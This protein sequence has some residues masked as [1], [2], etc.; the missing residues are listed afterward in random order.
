[1]DPDEARYA[2][3]SREMIEQKSYIVPLFNYEPRL[4]KPI[5]FYWSQI[6]SFKLFGINEF[7]ARFPSA[8]AALATIILV[9][10]IAKLLFNIDV[11][12]L[13]IFIFF[14]NILFFAFAK[15]GLLEVL[16]LFSFTL[17]IYFF[18]MAETSLVKWK[19]KRKTLYVLLFFVSLGLSF[20]IKGPVGVLV[21]L[22]IVTVYLILMK[23]F[24]PFSTN[25]IISGI[26]LFLAVIVPW[27]VA[28]ISKEG[29]SKIMILL[30][31]ET[32]ER[33]F[34]GFDHPEPF[35]YYIPIFLAGFFPWSSF[36]PVAVWR[37]G[38]ASLKSWSKEKLFLL[39]WLIFPLLFFSFSGSKLP[40]YILPVLPAASLIVASEWIEE[41][42][43]FSQ[44]NV[45]KRRWLLKSGYTLLTIFIV[46][47]CIYGFSI[48]HRYPDF[49]TFYF[50]AALLSL[51]F[52]VVAFIFLVKKMTVSLFSSILLF[53]IFFL[54]LSILFFMPIVQDMR[55]TK[56]LVLAKL[57]DYPDSTICTYNQKIPSLVFYRRQKVI[58]I[59]GEEKLNG[60][61]KSGMKIIIVASE[62]N[63]ENLSSAL[64]GELKIEGRLRKF[65]ILRPYEMNPP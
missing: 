21:P 20:L 64:K 37:L 44:G 56:R 38:K 57:V 17:S 48:L 35:F 63:Y 53:F 14:A 49:T 43:C 4:N 60:I 62:K 11:A 65:L 34:V 26:L 54:I 8:M 22:F 42:Y 36:I 6:I 55:S 52:A 50:F 1:M 7:A 10:L 31:K 2:E 12:L 41:K 51:I 13:S 47:F 24:S 59:G 27:G 45:R 32:M 40:G 58:L 19:G 28:L 46:S 5:L 3:T 25:N 33:Y 61:I 39:I 23:R 30:K 16:L 15:A 18:L 29:L 9:F